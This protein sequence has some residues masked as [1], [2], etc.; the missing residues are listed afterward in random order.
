MQAMADHLLNVFFTDVMRAPEYRGMRKFAFFGVEHVLITA[1]APWTALHAQRSHM[2]KPLFA[3]YHIFLLL[4]RLFPHT[5]THHQC[6]LC[7]RVVLLWCMHN[8]LLA[9]MS[10]IQLYVRYWAKV[11]MQLP[12]FQGPGLHRIAVAV[13]LS[14]GVKVLR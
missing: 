9:G 13:P 1:P 3:G 8:S 14:S 2:P 4:V 5:T 7:S 10:Q 12:L 6:T 11:V